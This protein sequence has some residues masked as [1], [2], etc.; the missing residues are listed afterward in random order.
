M[1]HTKIVV[2]TVLAGI[3]I[4]VLV[5]VLVIPRHAD[6][7]DF[8]SPKTWWVKRI[9]PDLY[10]AGRLTERQIKYASEAGFGTIVSL[11]THEDNY[12]IGDDRVLNTTDSRYVAERLGGIA[13]H[14]ILLPGDEMARLE[15]VQKFA[16]VMAWARK[17]ILLHCFTAQSASLISLSYLSQTVG[18]GSREIYTRGALLGYTFAAKDHYRSLIEAV[19]GEQP[20]AH[21]PTPDVTLPLWNTHYWLIKSVYKNWYMAGQ[22]QMNQAGNLSSLGIDT[23]VNCRQPAFSGILP[24]LRASQEEVELLNVKDNT[25]TY[26]GRGRQSTERLLATRID[27]VKPNEYVA[28]DSTV[29]YERKNVL[30]YGDD[31]GYN[32]AAEKDDIIRHKL[33]YCQTPPDIS[34]HGELEITIQIIWTQ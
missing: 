28:P 11:F 1:A 24:V 23:I 33:F 27:P 7:V 20:L 14:V 6:H 26:V 31:I 9:S 19:T 32:A 13:F 17:P 22:I 2:L 3:A 4:L 21:P 29:N 12:S 10:T 15:T 30:E 34:E 16:A 5:A 25:G 8:P 18:F